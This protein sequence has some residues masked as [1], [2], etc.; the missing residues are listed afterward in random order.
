MTSREIITRVLACDQPARIGLAYSGYQG[1][2]RLDDVAWCGPAGDPQRPETPWR[3]NGDGFEVRDDE[4]GCRWRRVKGRT[5]KGEVVAAPL[6][7]WRD[8]DSYRLPTFDDPRRYE[9]C[10][11]VRARCADRYLLGGL[12]GCAFNYARYLRRFDQYLYDCAAEPDQVRRLNGLLCDLALAQIDQYARIGA[13]GVMFA[14]DWG[15][16][17][18]LLVSPRMWHE[19]FESD[20]RRL[21]TRAHERGLTVWMHSCGYIK[22]I[23]PTLVE[24]GLDVFQLDQPDLSGL[25]FLARFPATYWCPVDIQ[26]VLP[27]GDERRIKAY[28]REMLAKLGGRGGGLIAKDYPD[29]P[30]IG[31]DPLWQHWGY[32]VFVAEGVYPP[33]AGA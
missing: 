31:V 23:I 25:D 13:D 30:S 17:D 32:E 11:E 4:W 15:T 27:T 9:R 16:E 26:R 2:A 3:D 7:E 6:A 28:A 21:I 24:M 18:R 1:Q 12:H 29:N 5:D 8:L 10:V 14:E 33:A 19:L 20:F 22:D